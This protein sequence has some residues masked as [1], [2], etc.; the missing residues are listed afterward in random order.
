MADRKIDLLIRFCLQ[1]GGRLSA[2]KRAS[3]FAF[4]TDDEIVRMEDSLSSDYGSDDQGP[5]DPTSRAATS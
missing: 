2:R 3:H 4:L 1:N 5:P